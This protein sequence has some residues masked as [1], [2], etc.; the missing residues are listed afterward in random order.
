MGTILSVSFPS[1]RVALIFAI[2]PRCCI[3]LDLLAWLLCKPKGGDPFQ[4]FCCPSP[5][6]CLLLPTDVEFLQ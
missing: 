2:S 1:L 4:S 3:D 5:P 6:P